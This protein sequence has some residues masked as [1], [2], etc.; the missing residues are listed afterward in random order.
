MLIPLASLYEPARRRLLR[1]V[2]ILPVPL[3]IVFLANQAVIKLA[4]EVFEAHPDLYDGTKY[5]VSYGL[6]EIKESVAQIA[7]AAALWLLYR[8]VS[9]QQR[10][11]AEERALT[12]T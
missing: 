6:Y 10:A 12:A 1:L 5:S 7:F 3:A 9:R 8:R 2:P 11:V 4:D